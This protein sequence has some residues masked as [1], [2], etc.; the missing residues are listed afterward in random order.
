MWILLCQDATGHIFHFL[1]TTFQGK[2]QN[3]S[4]IKLLKFTNKTE[5]NK[6]HT[7]QRP[8]EINNKTP[9]NKPPPKHRK[10]VN[11]ANFSRHSSGATIIC[12]L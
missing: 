12:Q 11:P 7:K 4:E 1:K 6:P 8:Q 10:A 2:A 3:E 5:T 9:T